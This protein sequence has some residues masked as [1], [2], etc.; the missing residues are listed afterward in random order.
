L[1]SRLF[2]RRPLTLLAS[3]PGADPSDGADGETGKLS[4]M[5]ER[6]QENPSII[7]SRSMGRKPGRDGGTMRTSLA[8]SSFSV[9]PG[10]PFFDADLSDAVWL[11]DATGGR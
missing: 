11:R 2:A 4:P 7:H 5:R 3:S 10:A 8:R 1:S 9:N 6:I